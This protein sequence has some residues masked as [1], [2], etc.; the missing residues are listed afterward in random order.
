MDASH[1]CWTGQIYT[2]VPKWVSRVQ[3]SNKYEIWSL[4][5]MKKEWPGLAEHYDV[6]SKVDLW[7]IIQNVLTSSYYPS[8]LC[9]FF[10][11]KIRLWILEIWPKTCFCES[12]VTFDPK[13]EPVHPGFFPLRLIY[14][15]ILC[16]IESLSVPRQTSLQGLQRSG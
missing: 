13:I 5:V 3:Y 2:T 1:T 7:P 10:K 4:R 6:G 8:Y 9:E 11:I 12:T 16:I 15:V 14:T